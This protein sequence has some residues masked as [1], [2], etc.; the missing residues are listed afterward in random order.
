MERRTVSSATEWEAKVGYSRAVRV[1]SQVHVAGTTATDESGDVV[2]VDDPY[3]QTQRAL[4]IVADA[5]EDAGA[6]T[7]DVVRTRLYVTD[8]DD[9]AEIGEAHG[10]VF[11]DVRPAASMVQVERLVDSDHLVEIEATAVVDGDPAGTT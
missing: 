11:G 6:G 1:G 9:W 2:G 5:L 3:T 10:E 7:E 8:I 4:E